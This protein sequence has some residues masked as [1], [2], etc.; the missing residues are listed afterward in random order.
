VLLRK[1]VCRLQVS[2]HGDL[3]YHFG[4]TLRRRGSMTLAERLQAMGTWLWKAFTWA[5][6]AW[7][8]LTLV[9]Y[10]IVFLVIAV[11]L[12]L[13]ASARDSADDR[14]RSSSIDLAPAAQPVLGHFSLAGDDWHPRRRLWP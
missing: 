4:E 12:L 8:A 9:L 5:Y 1:Y 14:R 11:V 3:I 2:E 10:F 7:I 6:K 13:A